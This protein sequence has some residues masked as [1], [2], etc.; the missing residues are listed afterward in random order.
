MK[1]TAIVAL[2]LLVVLISS[3]SAHAHE[4][5]VTDYY[6]HTIGW[7]ECFSDSGMEIFNSTVHKFIGI[8]NNS[9]M[10]VF[11]NPVYYSSSDCTSGAFIPTA[12]FPIKDQNALFRHTDNAI[13]TFQPTGIPLASM[14]SVGSYTSPAFVSGSWTVLC[15][16]GTP[17]SPPSNTAYQGVT[18]E[19]AKAS[20]LNAIYYFPTR[21]GFL[22]PFKYF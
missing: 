15:E 1:S 7:V 19:P 8:D 6:N 18:V 22:Y 16:T 4:I 13:V 20:W 5:Q 10:K 17:P 12:S 3:G 21:G 9:D 2:S 14:P 11:P